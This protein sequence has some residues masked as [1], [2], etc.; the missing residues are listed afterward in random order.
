MI[1]VLIADD[2]GVARE[3]VGKGVALHRGERFI[4]TEMVDNGA[5]ALEILRKKPIDIAFVDIHMPGLNG[6]QVVSAMRETQSNRCLTVAMSNDLDDRA[7]TVLKKFGA[8]H[9][10]KK[11]FQ[12]NAVADIVAT[13]RL[14]TRAYKLLIVDDSATM[15][16]LTRKILEKSRFSFE[17]SEAPSAEAAL[18]MLGK[19]KFDLVLTDFHMPDIDGLEL[20]G[21]L[22]D[23]SSNIGIYMMSTNDTT[24][25]ERSASFIGING[26]L[27]KPFTAEDV[28]TVMHGFLGLDNPKFG[29][30]RDM[31]SFMAKE[32]RAS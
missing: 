3:M 30:L 31:F 1:R 10:L 32:A 21:R 14:M 5:A 16:K 19:G 15:R 11:P 27:K 24:Y 22:R 23:L 4:E 2:S 28:D 25:L 13:F 8:Y 29:K 6:P 18:Q 7:E 20:A 26:F 9:F 12:I 17:I